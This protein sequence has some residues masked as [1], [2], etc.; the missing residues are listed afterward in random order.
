MIHIS[1]ETDAWKTSLLI[2]PAP[3]LVSL[4]LALAARQRHQGGKI[5]AA[6]AKFLNME[7]K[8]LN[9]KKTRYGGTEVKNCLCLNE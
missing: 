4:L 7:S 2:N 9:T 1:Y 8:G 6:A 3:P 5:S